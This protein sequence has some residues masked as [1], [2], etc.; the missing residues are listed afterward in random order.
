[1]L[2]LFLSIAFLVLFATASWAQSFLASGGAASPAPP[3]GAKVGFHYPSP[4][5]TPQ[6]AYAPPPFG[7]SSGACAGVAGGFLTV[8]YTAGSTSYR[9][10]NG[11]TSPC[12]GHLYGSNDGYESTLDIKINFSAVRTSSISTH[13]GQNCQAI[14]ASSNL[15]SG[16]A[17][18][19]F[20]FEGCSSTLFV[21]GIHCEGANNVTSQDCIDF[22]GATNAGQVVTTGNQTNGG[23]YLT[24]LGTVTGIT[25]SN[26][27]MLVTSSH[28]GDDIQVVAV[29]PA[30]CTSPCVQISRAAGSNQTAEALTF[31]RFY[32]PHVYIQNIV[33]DNM[34][35]YVNG[36]HADCM[37]NQNPVGE[38]DVDSV[39]CVT[40]YQCLYLPPQFDWSTLR[41][42][43]ANL[44]YKNNWQTLATVAGAAKCASNN[45][46]CITL[47]ASSNTCGGGNTGCYDT[48]S[49]IQVSGVGGTTEAN[50][51]GA[52]YRIIDAN[53]LDL[54]GV[55]FINAFT[56]NGVVSVPN[57]QGTLVMS[58]HDSTT[59]SFSYEQIN[60]TYLSDIYASN[61]Q[62]LGD[63]LGHHVA[64][65]LSSS[66]PPNP[67]A[68][69]TWNAAFDVNGCVWN[70]L[71]RNG[72]DFANRGTVNDLTTTAN[73]FSTGYQ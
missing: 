44:T 21:E 59:G 63:P 73:Y 12:D 41:I 40:D 13:G 20:A 28:L 43:R 19:M 58:L 56:S 16:G 2:R 26:P 31:T 54:T 66:D 15:T 8:T 68:C 52:S 30:G 34:H 47:S 35:G 32:T 38:I 50:V 53:T 60:P 14:G 5:F 46:V 6:L 36:T 9:P 39:T 37:Q 3:V 42:S 67:S 62:P 25:A 1:M 61:W 18:A 48:D 10:S 22:G 55:T 4:D 17:S 23:I 65:N 51:T 72:Q 45:D 49:V 11:E 24:N 69:L 71:Q 64:P 70:V 29:N 7:V 33:C 57:D 27:Q